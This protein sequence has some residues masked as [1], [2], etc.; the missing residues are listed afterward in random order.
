ME[1][2]GAWLRQNQPNRGLRACLPEDI[3]VYLV[4]WWS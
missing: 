1:E 3:I 2:L 4:S